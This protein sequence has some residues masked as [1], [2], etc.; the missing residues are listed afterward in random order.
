V[1]T[2]QELK[3]KIVEQIDEVDFLDI[4]GL[5]TKD[6]VEAFEDE[7]EEQFPKFLKE[8]DLPEENEDSMGY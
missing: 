7:I 1:L 6:L 5:T 3:E 2:L 4:L 8:L